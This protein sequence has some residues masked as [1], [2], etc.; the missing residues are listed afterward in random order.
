[1]V[2]FVAFFVVLTPLGYWMTPTNQENFS[3]EGLPPG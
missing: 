1:M 3:A 2:G